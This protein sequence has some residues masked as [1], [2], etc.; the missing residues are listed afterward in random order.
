MLLPCCP[1]SLP[2]LLP[3]PCSFLSLRKITSLWTDYPV[4]VSICSILPDSKNPCWFQK[5]RG[6]CLSIDNTHSCSC[7]YHAYY[8]LVW[9]YILAWYWSWEEGG[10]NLL[11]EGVFQNRRNGVERLKTC[12][13]P[14]E[15]LTSHGVTKD[16]RFHQL[17]LPT[18]Q[19]PWLIQYAPGCLVLGQATLYMPHC[20][21][22]AGNNFSIQSK[23]QSIRPYAFYR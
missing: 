6:S 3:F 11:T 8:L 14:D 1:I 23:S 18:P 22:T 5:H 13:R 20:P 4:H 2:T 15:V 9:L 12:Q 10:T 19:L 17:Q 21:L 16:L 7:L